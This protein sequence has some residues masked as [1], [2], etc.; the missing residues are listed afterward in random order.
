MRAAEDAAVAD[1]PAHFGVI[2]GD[3][4]VSNFYYTPPTAAA[5]GGSGGG[6]GRLSIFDWDQ[7]SARRVLLHCC[8][9]LLSRERGR[10]ALPMTPTRAVGAASLIADVRLCRCSAG[11]TCGTS[12]SRC[13]AR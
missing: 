5:D 8:A 13:S 10:R 12:R 3:L 1:D 2:H 7:A 9:R 6:G 11:G 4:N